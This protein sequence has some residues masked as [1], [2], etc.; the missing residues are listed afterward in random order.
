MM[1]SK[2]H[3]LVNI[4]ISF[5]KLRLLGSK[6]KLVSDKKS[7]KKSL[8]SGGKSSSRV[9]DKANTKDALDEIL[10]NNQQFVPESSAAQDVESN[11]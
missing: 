10:Q 7:S 9:L 6:K 5:R 2:R 4:S 11:S 3:L 1:P 8:K